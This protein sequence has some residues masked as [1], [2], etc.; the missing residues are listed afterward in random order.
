MTDVKCRACG[1][2][3]ETTEPNPTLV[4]CVECGS[5][6]LDYVNKSEDCHV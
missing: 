5:H 4:A 3:R 1:H 6:R 2:V